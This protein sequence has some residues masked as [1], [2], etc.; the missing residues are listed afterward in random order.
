MAE[1][2]DEFMG[3]LMAMSKLTDDFSGLLRVVEAKE[4]SEPDDHMIKV[5]KGWILQNMRRN[6]DAERS[7]DEALSLNPRSAWASFRKGQLLFEL[8]RDDEALACFG[9]A[10]KLKPLRADFWIEKAL[11]E[12]RL[13]KISGSLDSYE[14]AIRLGDKSGWALAGKARIQTYLNRFEEAL[15]TIRAAIK[16]EPQEEAFKAH[17]QVILDKMRGY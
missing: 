1:S 3:R 14:K 15:D 8:G 17:E 13:G 11:V 10:V 2:I 4:K 16:L 6:D 7:F 12:D 5:L 9:K